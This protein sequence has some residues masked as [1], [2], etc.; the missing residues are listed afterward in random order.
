MSLRSKFRG[1]YFFPFGRVNVSNVTDAPRPGGLL[2]GH[3][4]QP[5]AG[6]RAVGP[7]WAATGRRRRK[8][9]PSGPSAGRGSPAAP[10]RPASRILPLGEGLRCTRTS[11]PR[12]PEPRWSPGRV[13]QPAPPQTP[14]KAPP[15]APVT[16]GT[17]RRPR[18]PGQ[19]HLLRRLWHQRQHRDEDCCRFH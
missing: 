15:R 13:G 6:E 8:S 17:A 2:P 10:G 3:R 14:R 19:M 11:P 1:I 7:G 18:F 16:Q 9:C 12:R 4:P 5:V